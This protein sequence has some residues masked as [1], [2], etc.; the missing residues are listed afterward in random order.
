[1][2]FLGAVISYA[3]DHTLETII[4]DNFL[5][6]PHLVLEASGLLS[7]GNKTASLETKTG[8]HFSDMDLSFL[9]TKHHLQNPRQ[10]RKVVTGEWN[11]I[12]QRKE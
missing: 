1:M 4:T 9:N 11:K 3:L 5:E 7:F 6:G 8:A 2:V 10:V 12:Y